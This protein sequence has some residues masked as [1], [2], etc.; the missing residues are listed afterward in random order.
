[1]FKGNDAIAPSIAVSIITWKDVGAAQGWTR[2]I[3]Y[4]AIEIYQDRL[5]DLLV[6]KG[7]A[8]VDIPKAKIGYCDRSAA[9][10]EELLD[11]FQRAYRNLEVRKTHEN[12]ESSRGY[13]FCSLVLAQSHLDRPSIRSRITLIDLAGGE[14]IQ[15]KTKKSSQTMVKGGSFNAAADKADSF[16][17]TETKFINSSRGAL[18]TFL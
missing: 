17:A 10:V 9:T 6:E 11:L 2:Q 16:L 14:R 8:K 5:K 15:T 3:K 4:S 7:E 1:M 13:F 12:K 18:R